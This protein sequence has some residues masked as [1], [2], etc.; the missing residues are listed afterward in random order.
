MVCKCFC[1]FCRLSCHFMADF[2]WCEEAFEF[3]QCGPSCPFFSSLLLHYVPYQKQSMPIPLSRGALYLFSSRS[4]TVSGFTFRCLIY[5]EL[6]FVSG[7]RVDLGLSLYIWIFIY[8]ST[9]YWRDCPSL[10]CVLGSLVKNSLP[11]YAWVLLW[12]LDSSVIFC[13]YASTILFDYS[14]IVAYEIRKHNTSWFDF[15]IISLSL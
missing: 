8:P 13:F 6:I 3:S 10:H 2:F 15:L 14:F 12:S 11:I 5:C 7:V 4:C 1:Q 9:I